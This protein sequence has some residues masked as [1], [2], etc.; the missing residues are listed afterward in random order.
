[1]RLVGYIGVNELE[2]ALSL[3]ICVDSKLLS[4]TLKFIGL[5]DDDV[6]EEIFFHTYSHEPSSSISS[7][8]E[9]DQPLAS[10]N[11]Y[12]FSPYMDQVSFSLQ[13]PL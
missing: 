4:L 1:M 3:S 7:L 10:L 11:L 6:D 8:Q 5:V 9:A 2:H 13:S 12:D